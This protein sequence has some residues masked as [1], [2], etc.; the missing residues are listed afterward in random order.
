MIINEGHQKIKL[1]ILL[2]VF[3]ECLL[4]ILIIQRTNKRSLFDKEV[5][6]K[7]QKY[8]LRLL[9]LFNFNYIFL[10]INNLIKTI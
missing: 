2:L 3:F 1:I 10:N 7:F 8:G 9:E 4:S 6:V 5:L